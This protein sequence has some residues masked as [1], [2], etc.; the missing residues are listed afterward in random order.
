MERTCDEAIPLHMVE[1]HTHGQPLTVK[2]APGMAH[3]GLL[4]DRLLRK[5]CGKEE[6]RGRQFGWFLQVGGVSELQRQTK[7][8]TEPRPGQDKQKTNTSEPRSGYHEFWAP[9]KH[10]NLT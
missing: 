1:S 6:K 10:I 2:V 4:A 5:E 8:T 9:I 3:V 7:N